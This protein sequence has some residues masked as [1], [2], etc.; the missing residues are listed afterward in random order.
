M[1]KFIFII[2]VVFIG[3]IALTSYIYFRKQPVENVP[4]RATLVLNMQNYIEEGSDKV[5]DYRYKQLKNVLLN[6]Q[7][8]EKEI[9]SDLNNKLIKHEM[10]IRE[11]DYW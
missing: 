11:A 9:R 4:K 2:A 7:E 1:R 5:T 3:L 10:Q 6:E 8:T